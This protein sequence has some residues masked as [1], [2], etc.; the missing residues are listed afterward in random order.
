ML[1]HQD[2]WEWSLVGFFMEET[3]T[4]PCLGYVMIDRESHNGYEFCVFPED[5]G[6]FNAN[7]YMKGGREPV[8]F[9]F[10]PKNSEEEMRTFVKN[11]IEGKVTL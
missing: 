4:P 9:G 5:D 10:P 7:L 1:I 2:D 11:Y 8:V 3:S 6:E